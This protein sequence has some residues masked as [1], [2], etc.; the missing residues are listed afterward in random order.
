[1]TLRK[2]TLVV[3]G[4]TLSILI[5]LLYATSRCT[6]LERF[7]VLDEQTGHQNTER[8]LCAVTEDIASLYSINYDWANWDETYAFIEDANEDYIKRNLPENAYAYTRFRINL[9]I[10]VNSAGEIIYD[11]GYD[12]L[13]EKET[14]VPQSLKQQLA[15]GSLLLSHPQTDGSLAGI[16]LL[17]EGPVLIDS[18]PIRPSGGNG[19]ARG[20]LIMG[21]YL[22]AE[23]IRRL[24][25]KLHLPLVLERYDLAEKSPEFKDVYPA[26]SEQDQVVVRP[27]SEETVAGYGLLM[28]LYGNPALILKVAMSR[29]IYR[30]GLASVHYFILPLLAF[31]LIF[32]IVVLLLIEKMV[33]SRLAALNSSVRGISAS[34]DLSLRVSMTGKDELTSLAM[35]VNK[36]LE[37]LAQSHRALYES[38]ERYRTLTENTY[39]LISEIDTKGRYLYVSPNYKDVLEYEPGDLLGKHVTDFIYQEDHAAVMASLGKLLLDHFAPGQ[40]VYR[41]VAKNREFCW[42]ESTGKTYSTAAGETRTVFVSRNISERQRFEEMIR[43]QAFHD[44]VTGLPNRM[45]FKDRLS[46]AIAH[47]KR[48]N[49]PLAVLYL[50]LDRFKVINDT[51]GHGLG[52]RLLKSVADRLTACV[53]EE[54]TVARLGGDEFTLLLPDVDRGENAAVVAK[55]IVESIRQ[56]FKIDGYELFITTSIGI[57]LHPN[58]GNDAE[59]LLKNADTAMY[60][61]KETGKNNYQLYN[62]SMNAKAFERLSLE[63]NLRRALSLNEF[64]VYYQPKVNINTKLIV[65]VEALARWQHPR[66][67]LVPPD[68]FIPVAEE[69]GL[70]VPIGEWILRTAC[71]QN[72]E[73]QEAGLP[74]IRV[75]VNLSA[76]QFQLQ[77]LVDTVSRIL[78]ETGLDPSWLELEITEKLVMQDSEYIFRVLEELKNMGIILTIDDFGSSLSLGYLRRFPVNKLKIDMSFVSEIGSN[79]NHEAIA[80]TVLYLGKSLNLGVIAEGVEN[81]KQLDFLKQ[82]NCSELQGFMFGRPVSASD[83]KELL[84]KEFE[85]PSRTT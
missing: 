39:D 12:F 85:F 6:M 31:C 48:Y 84:Q 78:Q 49:Q 74:P 35:A 25:R 16:I 67:G 63:N 14:A 58:D 52:D 77:N 23:E 83:F 70:I 4:V 11:R 81:E 82:H 17:P 30:L 44:P 41:A 33:L 50:D 47:A 68:Q 38:K 73:W 18:Q 1:M 27:L 75:A 57:V 51:L 2:K 43:Y 3:F 36:M 79:R 32:G 72:K 28:D 10:Y 21:R 5:I 22:D 26:L 76:R 54:D 45:L 64:V 56:P 13:T 9:I 42:L 37:S 8:A 46:L 24:A 7:A 80:A 19:P 60:R 66:L 55:K 34:S 29:D 53:S 20:T 71:A 59:T 62:P 69:T 15:P 40:L 61:A 65:G